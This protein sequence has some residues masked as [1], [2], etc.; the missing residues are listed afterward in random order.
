MKFYFSPRR[1]SNRERRSQEGM[2]QLYMRVIT[3]CKMCTEDR[4]LHKST[5]TQYRTHE[6]ALPASG[7]KWKKRTTAEMFGEEEQ[8]KEIANDMHFE[9]HIMGL[10]W[11]V[12][13]EIGFGFWG[14][15]SMTKFKFENKARMFREVFED[16]LYEQIF[17][18]SNP[19]KTIN[20]DSWRFANFF[21]IVLISFC[22]FIRYL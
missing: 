2:Q 10:P 19:Y 7:A 9:S 8:H 11:V 1:E 16:L 3:Q 17:T 20:D 22:F 6:L 14:L 4:N 5:R 13:S 18:G 21:G 12:S 15:F